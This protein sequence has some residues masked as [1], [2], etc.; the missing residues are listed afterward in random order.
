MNGYD[1][2]SR[3]I[4]E[5]YGELPIG[6]Y[7]VSMQLENENWTK[8]EEFEVT[9]KYWIWEYDWC[10]GESEIKILTLYKEMDVKIVTHTAIN[11][12]AKYRFDS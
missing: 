6:K 12:W 10:E 9:D 11:T 2:A 1:I 3:M 5:K 4:E 8:Y 7:V